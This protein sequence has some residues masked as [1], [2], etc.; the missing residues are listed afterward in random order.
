MPPCGTFGLAGG[1]GF[2]CGGRGLIGVAGFGGAMGAIGI[3]ALGIGGG[4]GGGI[5]VSSMAFTPDGKGLA[6]GLGDT[7]YLWGLARRR[8]LRRFRGAQVLASAFAFSPDGKVLAA[9]SQGG[10]VHLWAADTGTPLC[11]ADG[12]R[13]PVT[14]VSFSAN[15]KVLASGGA[16]ATALAWDVKSLL[17]EWRPRQAA[18]SPSRRQALWEGLGDVDAARAYD[19]VWALAADP[20]QTT[21]FMQARLRPVAAVDPQRVVRL[22]ADL[23]SERYERRKR[24]T[25]ELEKLGDAAEAALR[26]VLAGKPSLE[27]RQRAEQLLQK[28]EEPITDPEQLRAVRSVEVLGRIDTL[29]ARQLLEKLAKGAPESRLTQQA[30]EALERQGRGAGRE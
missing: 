21:A 9:G 7:I 1:V 8:E 19:A 26:K 30:Q 3:G 13:G 28:L 10:K 11:E 6:F 4:F 5:P 12:H 20:G 17:D 22:V 23:D 2:G 25:E 29:E 18:L 14:C 27:M 15:G 24:A 16:D